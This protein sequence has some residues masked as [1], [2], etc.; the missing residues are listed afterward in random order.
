MKTTPEMRA[1][2]RELCHPVAGRD[3]YDR[4]V[5][6]LLDDFETELTRLECLVYVPGVWRCAK[7]DFRLIQSN[8]N[9]NTGT[10]TARDTPGDKCPNC[11]S[12][13]WRVTE[14]QE[15]IEALDMLEKRFALSEQQS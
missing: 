6:A 13:L 5:L 11:H 4:A 15:R 12:P 7:C 1:R 3:D 10:I 14:R 2:L 8:L 9:A